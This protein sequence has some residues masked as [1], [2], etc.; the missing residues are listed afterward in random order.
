MKQ[1]VYARN[2]KILMGARVAKRPAMLS[3]G[4]PWERG[5]VYVWVLALGCTRRLSENRLPYCGG[6][7][8]V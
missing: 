6:S 1:S 8:L 7:K 3:H 2:Y 5:D 4:G